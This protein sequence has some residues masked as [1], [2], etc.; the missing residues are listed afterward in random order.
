MVDIVDDIRNDPRQ[1]PACEQGIICPMIKR[2]TKEYLGRM[3]CDTC[4]SEFKVS[5]E[6]HAE[7][8]GIT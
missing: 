1:C 6:K 3:I 2:E 4:G 8:R 7:L 5:Y